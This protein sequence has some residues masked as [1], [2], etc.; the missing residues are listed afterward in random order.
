MTTDPE[1]AGQASARV[2]AITDE[3]VQLLWLLV[4]L[5]D[6]SAESR[7]GVATVAEISGR[8]GLPAPAVSLFLASL[9]EAGFVTDHGPGAAGPAIA[10]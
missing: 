5:S 10:G 7:H 4:A 1:A 2:A 6:V 3:G 8:C 9:E